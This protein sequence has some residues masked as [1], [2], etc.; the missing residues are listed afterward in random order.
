MGKF[1]KSWS[2][3]NHDQGPAFMMWDERVLFNSYDHERYGE[4]FLQRAVKYM[5]DA[6]MAA[7]MEEN[8]MKKSKKAQ[9]VPGT[10]AEVIRLEQ[11]TNNLFLEPLATPNKSYGTRTVSSPVHSPS[12][13]PEP[14]KSQFDAS[15][16]AE[17]V[18]IMRSE[19]RVES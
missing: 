9:I 4:C 19:S 6:W 16:E 5:R 14:F 10:S 11:R 1:C 7:W 17:D 8:A 2:D 18:Y 13:G 15:V 12:D 3:L